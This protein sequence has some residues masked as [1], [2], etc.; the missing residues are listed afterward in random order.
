MFEFPTSSGLLAS[1][2]L[3]G[4]AVLALLGASLGGYAIHERNNAQDLNA[5]NQ[6]TT[7]A[8]T[9]TKQE[10]MD[11]TTRVNLLAAQKDEQAAAPT[12]AADAPRTRRS[13][14]DASRPVHVVVHHQDSRYSKLQ[15]QVD[16]QGK[17]IEETKNALAGT[18]SDLVNTRTELTG[19]IAHTHDE[20][21]L[22]EKKGERNYTEFDLY[23]SKE[24][25][26][27]GPFGIRLKKANEKH[28][29]ADL[30]LI[31]DDRNLQ[32]K[33]V[34]LYQPVMFSTPDSPQASEVVI[35][36][37]SKNHIHGYISAPKYRQSELASMANAADNGAQAGNAQNGDNDIVHANA[38]AAPPREKLP[39]PQQ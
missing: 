38:Q 27:K 21:V 13:D 26:H 25:Q 20:L 32:Q 35:N 29:Y 16:A 5:K 23:K 30:E 34:N 10:L 14:A 6:Q 2:H 11:L 7:A 8:L 24:F 39:V 36:N 15:A 18:Q 33:H 1:K 22:L 31:V 12:R 3:V 9:Q 37:V 17:A 28:Q 19:S 4:Y